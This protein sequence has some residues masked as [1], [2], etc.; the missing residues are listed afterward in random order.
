MDSSRRR[1][2]VPISLQP[3]DR[4]RLEELRSRFATI[5]KSN[6]NTSETVRLAISIGS[7][8]SHEQVRQV[9][10]QTTR[11]PRGRPPIPWT[12]R[13]LDDQ[14]EEWVR[15]EQERLQRLRL[16]HELQVLRSYLVRTSDQE[17]RLEE[18]CRELNMVLA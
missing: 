13:Y 9:V 3:A 14:E 10:L 16:I 1:I 4:A 15:E 6:I 7:A 17:K 5:L 2:V 8:A 12:A 11:I 18:I